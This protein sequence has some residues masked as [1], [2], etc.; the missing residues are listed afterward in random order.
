MLA[1]KI[2][3]AYDGSKCSRKAVDWALA[4]QK[5]EGASVTV[6]VVTVMPA[7]NG[8]FAYEN[9]QADLAAL[10]KSQKTDL[11]K[12]I[13]QLRAECAA[14]GQTITTHM[15]EGNVA[16]A[17]LDHVAKSEADLVVT[18]T[19]GVGG[20]EKVILGSIA[21]KLVTYANVPVVVIR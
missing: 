13:E 11:E 19:R 21:D 9:Y 4:L 20:F 5:L 15:L 12:T 7:T 2:M 17:L 14:N 16:E 18:G 10:W 8:F 6:D 1:N 3:V